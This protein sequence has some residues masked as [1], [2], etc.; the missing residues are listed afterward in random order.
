[1]EFGLFEILK[2]VGALGFFIYGM[3]I[4]SEGIQK[5]AGN[6]MR[7]ILSVMT[8]NR[9]F[10]LFTGFL[11]T[12]IVQSSSASTVMTVSFVNA[13][14]LTLTESI[15]VIM[16]ANIGTTITGWLISIFGFKVKIAAI[17]LPIIAV[18]APMLF[19][20]KGKIKSWG[21]FLIGFAL[22]FMGLDELKQS[23]PDLKHN[24]EVL[25]FLAG[26]ADSGFLSLIMF[27][28]VGTLLTVLVQSSS[29]AM[30]LTLVMCNEGWIPF[31]IAAG[32]ILGENIGTTITANLAALVGN[33]HAK[34]AARAHLIF[35]L[36]GV[37]WMLF[38]FRFFIAGIDSY[39]LSSTGNSPLLVATS[40]PI[41][42]SLFHTTF[43]IMN[44]VLLIGFV[45]FIAKLVIKMV[46]SKGDADEEYSL[47]YISTGIM[48]TPEMS[49]LEAQKE[50]AKFGNVARKMNGFVK[51]LVTEQ[52]NKKV[53]Q[54][55]A[56]IKK[57]EDITDRIEADVAN[58]LAKVSE[59]EMS[60]SSSIKIRGMLSIIGDLER[61]GD[62]YYQMSKTIERKNESKI[63]FTPEQ[64]NNIN[65]M[66]EMA[67]AGLETMVAN[68][69]GVSSEV[70]LVKANEHETALNIY[71]KKIRKEH[72]ISEEKG[73]Y[74]FDSATIY[75]DLFNSIEKVGDHTINVTEGIV[76]EI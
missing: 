35:N 7:D 36:F 56:R 2:L 10:G 30:A 69:E 34:R 67:E 70:T 3:K 16:G 61:I 11:I 65:E 17:A 53:S 8:S 20:N 15:G 31:D 47:E 51:G 14:L 26:Y 45:P 25:S 29:A 66:F 73:D 32:M 74:N 60:E 75:S 63:W 13:G 72:L 33:V 55:L 41:A 68:L 48:A 6:K 57:Y 37:V 71:R 49:I 19:S 28:G 4:M 54:T 43:N 50:V 27:I 46:P 62:I 24:P 22:L 52:D 39:M 12:S 1:M 5:I 23:V 76:G 40:V 42:L 21:E 44:V 18:G 9:F 58:Y 59:G 38:A 64:R